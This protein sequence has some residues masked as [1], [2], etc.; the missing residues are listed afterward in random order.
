MDTEY[1]GLRRG[2][3]FAIPPD[4]LTDVDFSVEENTLSRVVKISNMTAARTS[5]M[6]LRFKTQ[7]GESM[8]YGFWLVQ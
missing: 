1:Q 3:C 6:Y 2:S 8:V 7:F 4:K 5:K